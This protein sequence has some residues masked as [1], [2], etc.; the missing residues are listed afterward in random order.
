MIAFGEMS[1]QG[2]IRFGSV[3]LALTIDQNGIIEDIE[4]E[5]NDLPQLIQHIRKSILQ[6]EFQPGFKDGKP[7]KTR[8]RYSVSYRSD[9][10]LPGKGKLAN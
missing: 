9:H 5:H 4:I 2:D 1:Y 7:V 10:F 6:W 3:V 8:A